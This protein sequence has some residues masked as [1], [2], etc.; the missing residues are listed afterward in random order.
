MDGEMMGQIYGIKKKDNGKIVYIGQTVRNYKTRWQQ[1]KQQAKV[2]PYALYRALNK[3]GVN[4]FYPVLIEECNNNLLD[5]REKYWIKFY[6]TKIEEEG[7]NLT[8]GGNTPSKYMC[9]EV[10]QYSLE[11]EYIQSFNSTVEAGLSLDIHP[12]CISEVASG[13]M[14]QSHNFRW[15]Y[16]KYNKLEPYKSR[17]RKIEQYSVDDKFIQ[18]FPSIRAAALSLN[19]PNGSTNILNAAKGKRKTAYGYKWK[20]LDD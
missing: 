14:K 3:Y 10:H 16:V 12:S 5:E 4:N 19:K 1:H 11:G 2:R 13:A 18:R 15:S 9:K 8:D 7:Y 6:H 20:I 17:L